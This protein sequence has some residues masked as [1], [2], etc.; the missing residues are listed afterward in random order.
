MRRLLLLTA[1]AGALAGAAVVSYIAR[2]LYEYDQAAEEIWRT[3]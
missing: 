1:A 3:R 2:V